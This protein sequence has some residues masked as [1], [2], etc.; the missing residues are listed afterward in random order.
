MTFPTAEELFDTT[1][2][3]AKELFSDKEPVWQAITKIKLFF[4]KL[5]ENPPNGYKEIKENIWVATDVKISEKATVIA[6][7][8][9]GKGSEIRP[10][11]YIR[12]Y[13]IIGEDVVIGNS[14]EIKNS[15]IFDWA[16][17]PHYNY[18]G[19]SII[20]YKAHMGAGVIASNYRLD[21]STVKVRQN[22]EKFDTGMR[23]LGVLLGDFSEVGCNSVLCPGT[24]IEKN[25]LIMP[26]STVVGIIKKNENTV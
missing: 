3:I 11:A 10:G 8:I 14:T 4:E 24:I 1:R 16:Q 5:K 19:D 20:G 25:T 18:V 12:G 15:I 26:L 13:A 22:N 21:H 9:I 2:T 17:L 23:K 7:T 6:P